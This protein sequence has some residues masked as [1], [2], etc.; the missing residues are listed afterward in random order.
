MVTSLFWL[1]LWAALASLLLAAGILLRIRLRKRL[2]TG[3]KPEVD[4]D[5]V[6]RILETGAL[7]DGVPE[8]LDLDEIEEE[9]RRF[10]SETW[11]EPEEW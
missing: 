6:R 2:G 9:E 5:A 8:P 7:D 11:D 3:R 1:V 10:W 4:D